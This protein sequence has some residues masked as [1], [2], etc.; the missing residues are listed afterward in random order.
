MTEVAAPVVAPEPVVAVDPL[1]PVP[2]PVVA[3]SVDALPEWAQKELRKVRAEAA[4]SRTKA[5]TA[6]TTQAETMDK[7]AKA[8]GLKGDD[9]PAAAAKTAAEGW[10]ASKTV[11]KNLAVENAVMRSA[12]KAGANADALTDSRS[13]MRALEALDPAA[14]DFKTQLDTA[15]KAAV[16]ANPSLKAQ[17]A[18][19]APARS[20]GPVG[21]GAPIPGQ[22]TAEDVKQMR[23]EG[24]DAEI[25][26]AKTD[27]RL[28]NLM[29][30]VAE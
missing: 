20:G 21:G 27:G 18:P 26:Q 3:E 5:T 24:R 7:I 9:D 25:V 2:E 10:E 1:A 22:L 6:E 14:D 23:A 17:G 16:E 19:V 30:Q 29:K 28:D 11:A 4:A 8:L 15:I 13:F 12:M